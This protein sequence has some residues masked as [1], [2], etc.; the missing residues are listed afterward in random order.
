[1]SPKSLLPT[2]FADF[3]KAVTDLGLE[4]FRAKQVWEWLFG[5]LVFD[6]KAMTNLSIETRNRLAEAFPVILPENIGIQ[7]AEDGTRKISLTLEDGAKIESVSLP[8]EDSLTFCLSSQIGCRI[9]CPFCRTGG[10]G[11][12]RNLTAE[13]I[14]LQMMSLVKIC[15]S[16]PTNIV[17]MGMGEPFMNRKAVF[18]AIDVF[19]DPRYLG[20]ATRRVTISTAGV[21][22]GIIELANRPG[23]V[24]LA[25]SLHVASDDARSMLVPLNRK[26]PLDSLRDAIVTYID[27]TNRRVSLEVTLLRQVNDQL[28]DAM[29]LVGFCE[30]LLCHVNIVRFNPFPSCNFRPSTEKAE[31]EFRKVLKKAG[32]PVTVRRSRG[33]DILAA[34]GQLAGD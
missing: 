32:I 12:I 8:D 21:P 7:T 25:V 20:L 23:E 14:G 33:A 17:F 5:K 27:R 26:F 29:N 30:G 13:E 18:G 28:S 22:E 34:C 3:Q 15:H 11:F 6:F 19:T 9:G 31:K 10:M 2:H 1:M 24:N 16:K 4:K